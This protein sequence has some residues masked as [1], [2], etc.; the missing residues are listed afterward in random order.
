M[1]LNYNDLIYIEQN[2]LNED[3]C[4]H[5]IEKFEADDRSY[6]GGA[7]GKFN[8]LV[9]LT[10]DLTISTLADWKE[11]D[12]IINSALSDALVKY[13]QH[14]SQNNGSVI[15]VDSYHYSDAG[16]K[17]Q[18]YSL[19]S[20]FELS[21]FYDW[22]SDF[23]I[24]SQGVR[25]LVFMWYL[26]DVEEG[27]ET[28]FCSGLKIKPKTGTVV[29]FPAS[30]YIMHRGNKPISNNKIICNGWIYARTM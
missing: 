8:P 22:H 2:S 23:C 6:P 24:D 10:T 27:G 25:L 14:V 7:G 13:S 11:E 26:N 12:S 20:E 19:H 30:W 3:F 29:I 4:K 1:A 17:I 5:L 18:K 9:K 28:E 16:Y 21:G 15:F